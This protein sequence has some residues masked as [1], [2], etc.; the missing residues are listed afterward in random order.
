M[1]FV[2]RCGD[3]VS[4]SSKLMLKS[5]ENKMSLIKLR[6]TQIVAKRHQKRLKSQ[7]LPRPRFSAPRLTPKKKTVTML[8]SMVEK[9]RSSMRRQ[10][11]LKSSRAQL[12]S[13]R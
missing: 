8:R 10:R 9:R 2:R 1:P 7:M 5:K 3:H 13:K 11:K 4:S 12:T 6:K